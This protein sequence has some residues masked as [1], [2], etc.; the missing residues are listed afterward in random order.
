MASASGCPAAHCS[1]VAADRQPQARADSCGGT[2]NGHVHEFCCGAETCGS[3]FGLGLLT[4]ALLLGVALVHVP[5]VLV[6]L[7][8]P[9]VGK[10]PVSLLSWGGGEKKE[11]VTRVVATC[12]SV[13]GTGGHR[14][15]AA[16]FSQS[17]GRI[18]RSV[19]LILMNICCRSTLHCPAS[20]IAHAR[21][22]V[23]LAFPRA[24][25]STHSCSVQ[26]S[27]VCSRTRLPS[28]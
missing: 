15:V 7:P 8:P 6:V 27:D 18:R 12:V 24:T 25:F 1:P 3:G 17:G 28:F 21:S 19:M 26:S 4:V 20:A 23:V 11:E 16:A 13:T 2:T 14:C 5:S 10:D 9:L 22:A